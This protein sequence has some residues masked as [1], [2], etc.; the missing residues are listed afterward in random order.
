MVFDGCLMEVAICNISLSL[1][2]FSQKVKW[3]PAPLSVVAVPR[4][5]G[6]L[7]QFFSIALPY[8]GWHLYQ[9]TGYH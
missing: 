7:G 2:V 8:H 4:Q 6:H 9:A 5:K 3:L 1:S